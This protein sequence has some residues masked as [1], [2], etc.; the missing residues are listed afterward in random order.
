MQSMIVELEDSDK[1]EGP[2]VFQT[3]D[4][5]NWMPEKM[6]ETVRFIYCS[7]DPKDQAVSYFHHIKL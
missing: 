5:W 2:R 3:H 7:K 4:Y 1:M 6:R